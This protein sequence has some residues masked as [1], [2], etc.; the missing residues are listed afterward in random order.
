MKELKYIW[1]LFIHNTVNKINSEISFYQKIKKILLIWFITFLTLF[2]LVPF[3]GFLSS[4]LETYFKINISLNSIDT[5]FYNNKNNI[6]YHN[7]ILYIIYILI[8]GPLIEE[9]I[10]RL[11]FNL[12]KISIAIFCFGISFLFIKILLSY[13]TKLPNL[14]FYTILFT[15]PLIFGIF[16]YL[17]ITTKWV[18]FFKT[19]FFLLL[20]IILFG[21][22]HIFNIDNFNN[23]FIPIYLFFSIPKMIVGLNLTYTRIK[24]GFFYGLLLHSLF[25]FGSVIRIL[26]SN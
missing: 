8:L 9:T 23:W 18:I 24:Y 14:H 15:I 19:R 20:N 26:I 12:K 17:K 10:F 21:S 16:I 7:K 11:V 3:F 1:E 13:F 5:D 22:I 25:N 4:L 6:L 2:I